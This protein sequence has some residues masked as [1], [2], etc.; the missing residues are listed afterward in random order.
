MCFQI[1]CCVFR[2]VI[3]ICN[4]DL[5]FAFRFV[6]CFAIC[7]FVWHFTCSVDMN[8]E[9]AEDQLTK[10]GD[11]R[12]NKLCDPECHVPSKRKQP[13]TENDKQSPTS[14]SASH[15]E[16]MSLPSWSASHREEIPHPSLFA[17]H[18]E[19]IPH[20]SWS[21]SH[22]EEM[23]LPSWSASHREEIP[24]PSWSASHS[25]EM[26]LPS[27]SASHREEIP[28][29]SWSASHSEEMSLPSWS[30]SHR[31]EIPHPSWSASHSEEMSLPSWSASH[32]EEIPHPSW[33]ASHSEEMSL[34]SWSASHREE[35]PHPSWSASHSEEMS[36][37]SWSASHREE[38]PHPS[39]SASH[40]EEMSLPS[41][42]ASHREEI[43]HPSWSASHSE[44]MSLPSWSASHREEIPH[45]SLFAS[46]REEI[47]HPSLFA[48]H[49]EEMSLP[50]WSASHREEIPHPSWSASHRE[51]IP[52]PSWSASH[53][54]E[55]SLLPCVPLRE[56]SESHFWHT[57]QVPHPVHSLEFNTPPSIE[58]ALSPEEEEKLTA[59][60]EKKK[61]SL[62]HKLQAFQRLRRLRYFP[63]PISRKEM[64]LA[65]EEEKPTADKENKS[66]S[67]SQTQQLSDC[68]SSGLDHHL[69]P[70]CK[71]CVHLVDSDEWIQVEPSVCRD[72]G[73]SKFRISTQ[74]G[75]YECIRTTM[76]WVCDCDVTLQY[77]AVDGR[78][79]ISE[80]ERL[81]CEQIG[82][83][84]D[85]TVISGKLM[86]AHLP[87]FACLAESDPTL[88]DA[89]KVLI[90]K[91]EGV[92]LQPVELTRF[93]AKIIQP[94]FCP[95]TPVAKTKTKRK[96]HFNLLL[97]MRCKNP[98]IL[99]VYFFPLNDTCSKD[100]VE[101]SER[102]SLQISHPRPDRPF[103]M[104]ATH[105][106][107]VPDASV[108]PIEGITF[109]RDIDPNFFKVKLVQDGDVPMALIRE[110]DTSVVWEATIWSDDQLNPRQIQNQPE[111]RSKIDIDNFVQNHWSALI[112]G[113]ENVMSI[114]DK[115]REQKIIQREIYSEMLNNNRTSQDRMRKI[116]SIVDAGNWS[117]KARFILILEEEEPYLFKELSK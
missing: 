96:E 58:M 13:N 42:S 39:W 106:L 94:S 68:T 74:P 64:S 56:M 79:L 111:Q 57:Q 61:H 47:P 25:E 90:Q 71:S 49:S 78:S 20:P 50:S 83:V 75:R 48:S 63:T 4:L 34:P 5:F 115:L 107:K 89:V 27:W 109:R 35:I 10:G 108:H 80:L 17:S 62:S 43:P 88:K 21:A 54:E 66:H 11:T 82:P 93:H 98:P 22:S 101:Q 53:S 12:K 112:Q 99:H 44:E 104:N 15:S 81:Q 30:A 110:K 103:Q 73:E 100:K 113:V 24:H 85:V 28:H 102:S 16:E 77:H 65:P 36:L 70:E 92:I 69:L 6:V 32:R 84:M 23:S 91:D 2:F 95:A 3:V 18:R 9:E 116:C 40:S 7:C 59:S 41:W 46:H 19:E 31:E 67:F 33:S 1:W 86:E 117:I 26:S 51:E 38:I 55:M 60:E 97:Y 105:F 87:H 72:E 76:R 29:P 114:A 37:P 45:P 14:W 52:H 8:V